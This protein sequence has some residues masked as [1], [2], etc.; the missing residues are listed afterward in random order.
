MSRSKSNESNE[1]NAALTFLAG[2]GQVGKCMRQQDWNQ[3]PLGDPAGWPQSLRTVT[4]LVLHSKAPMY[5]AW[6]ADLCFLY[7]DAFLDVIGIKHPAALGRPFRD[8]WPEVWNEIAPLVARTLA[9]ESLSF[10]NRPFTLLRKGYEELAWFSFS[11]SPLHDEQGAAAGLFCSLVETT[12][13]VRAERERVEETARLRQ[14]FQQAPSMMAVVRGPDH[15]YELANAAYLQL[16]GRRDAD[17]IGKS[18]A[19]AV[20]ELEKQGFI[21]LLNQVY[22]SGK[23]HIGRSVPIEMRRPEGGVAQHYIDFIY[24][25]ITDANGQVS[26]IFSLGIDVSEAVHAAD[27]LRVSEE[28]VRLATDAAGLAIWV[29]D[30]VADEVIWENDWAYQI[31]GLHKGHAPVNSAQFMAEFLYPEDAAA[32]AQAVA[33]V[34]AGAPLY[35]QG[36]FYRAPNRE[37]CWIEFKGR[38][39]PHGKNGSLKLLGTAADI[40]ERKVAEQKLKDADRRKDEFLAMLAHELR[41]PLAPIGAAADLLGLARPDEARIRQTSE[42]ISRQVRHMSGLVDDL[43]DVSRVTRGLVSLDKAVLDASRI[44]ADAIEQ[45]R[46]LLERRRHHLAMNLSPEPAFVHG[47]AKRLVQVLVNLLNNAAKY[48]P[49]GG[50]ISL[51]MQARHDE[52]I[53][54]IADDGIGMPPEL[55]ARAF[56]LFAQAERPADRSQGGLGIGLA[57][58]KS[59][60]ELHEGSVA[61]HSEGV[62]KGSRFTVC[63]PRLQEQ[64][65]LS[66]GESNAAG[67]APAPALKVIVVDDNADAAQMLA[68]FVEALGHRVVVEHSAGEAL[69]RAKAEAPHVCLLDIGLPEMDGNELARRLRAQP[70]TAKSILVAVTGY[71]QEQDKQNAIDAGFDHHF[72]KPVDSKKLVG[73]LSDIAQSL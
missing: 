3:S 1:E 16:I 52:V 7:N 33:A 66:A 20:P 25:P 53:F 2:G 60:V 55:V 42:I 32:F 71:G 61:A 49:E 62:G 64:S 68:M 37:L 9:G 46:P 11:Y 24:Q 56:E 70:E 14:L 15:V 73:L 38:R 51:S 48:T 63:L 17:V 58:V 39:L 23:P 22:A 69:E 36:R 30:P 43:L 27:A 54:T 47:D 45:V 13:R 19:D 6:G 31:F 35:F 26:G 72:I 18:A 40:T 34:D 10:E 28:R 8:V 65:D 5:F 29:W 57:L 44:V 4:S 21:A 59:L 41:N 50:H 12:A 67:A